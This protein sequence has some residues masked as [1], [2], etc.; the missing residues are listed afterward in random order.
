MSYIAPVQS[1]KV[2]IG[3]LL[4]SFSG[5]LAEIDR[6]WN[7]RPWSAALFA[8]ELENQCSKGWGAFLGDK[9]IGYLLSQITYDEAHIVTL[10]VSKSYRSVGVGRTLLWTMISRL[11]RE[12]VKK[13]SLEVRVSNI[14]ARS[15]Y[16]SLDF[17]VEG[18]RR[19]Y[20]SDNGEDALIMVRETC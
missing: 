9:L 3:P 7:P 8:G 12:H 19:R 10:G 2:V 16:E 4:S 18:L 11:E 13:I 5:Q 1:P 17:T 6:E 14:P 20:Y 15:L